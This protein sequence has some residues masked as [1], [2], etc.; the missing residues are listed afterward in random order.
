MEIH[1]RDLFKEPHLRKWQNEVGF[2]LFC[3]LWQD[4][5]NNLL[6]M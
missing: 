5:V 6:L 4:G 3:E 2:G 1:Q